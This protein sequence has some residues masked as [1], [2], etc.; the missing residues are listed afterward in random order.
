MR[1][2]LRAMQSFSKIL[3]EDCG[4]QVDANGKDYIRRIISG[5]ARMDNLIQDVLTY[6]RVSRRDLPLQTVNLDELLRD[7]VQTYPAFQP[8][9]ARVDLEG[10]F[11]PVF[12]IPAVLTQCISN[13]LG[14][15]VKFV[16]PEVMP[17]IR[18]WAEDRDL[19][20]KVRVFFKDNGLGIEKDAHETIFGIFQR[21]SKNFEGTGI[22]LS[23]VKKGVERMGGSVS[24]VS[25]LG[26]GSTFWLDLQKP[27]VQ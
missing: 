22:G 9:K 4:D 13:L 20:N 10:V 16:A 15:A 3:M 23:I 27:P 25:E 2:P 18:V 7:I 11:P 17:H 24:L 6:S 12:A 1:A 26:E 5:A 8:P 14:N 19:N 21:V